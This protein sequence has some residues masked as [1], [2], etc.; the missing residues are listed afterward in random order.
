MFSYASETSACDLI[1]PSAMWCIVS[2]G[3]WHPTRLRFQRIIEIQP[4]HR[5]PHHEDK[6][7]RQASKQQ[8]R[9]FITT[10]RLL[11]MDKRTIRC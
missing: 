11:E 6:T 2:L 8:G 10:Q 5:K 9:S 7:K 4:V 1:R 3:I